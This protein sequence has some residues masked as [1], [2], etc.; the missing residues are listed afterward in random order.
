MAEWR[1]LTADDVQAILQAF[2]IS[3]YRGHRP[4]A[5]GTINTNIRVDTDGEPLFLR[6][7]E[8]KS[9]GDV[10]READI[11][12]W[13]AAR[14]VPTPE[15][16][17]TRD[18][19]A[20]AAWQ[21]QLASLFPWVAGRTLARAEL[22]PGHG[23]AAGRALAQLHLAGAGHPDRARGALRARRNRT[24]P[25]QRGRARPRGAGARR[26]DPAAGA[27]RAGDGAPGAAAL[28]DHPRRSLRRQ[29]ALPRRRH[30]VGAAGL[31]AGVMGALGVRPGRHRA[32]L[33]VR[34]R[35]FSRRRDARAAGRLR[36]RP[37][38]D[39]RRAR[40]LRRRAA[41]RRVP[42]RRHPHH[43]RSPQARVGRCARENDFSAT[44]IAWRAS[45]TTSPAIRCWRSEAA[46]PFC[47]AFCSATCGPC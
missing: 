23:A 3:G 33:R 43:R 31:R 47:S 30:L 17:R 37:A 19:K 46:R 6:I 42:L 21:D 8:G 1:R 45:S 34:P 24:P 39:R 27:A 38:A 7:N 14:G 41:V 26:G 22:T 2:G 44:W 15:P 35:R 29:R 13:V 32:G 25:G 40:Q 12:S 36:R 10:E 4:I 16:H 9:R 18:G 20:F 5:V 28:R 11:V